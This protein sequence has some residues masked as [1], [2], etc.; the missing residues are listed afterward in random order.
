MRVTE[1]TQFQKIVREVFKR[2]KE[3]KTGLDARD[4]HQ[5]RE[6]LGGR[7]ASELLNPCSDQ[8]RATTG[9]VKN[10]PLLIL[11]GRRE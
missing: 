7:N 10:H 3:V 6:A 11:G 4:T 5:P 9:F 1:K 2:R 8:P